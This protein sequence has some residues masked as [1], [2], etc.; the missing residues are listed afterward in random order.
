[1]LDSF[2]YGVGNF[3]IAL[4]LVGIFGAHYRLISE[5]GLQFI[6]TIMVFI[7]YAYPAFIVLLFAF[8]LLRWFLRK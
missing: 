8:R 1:M 6:A 3:F 2:S 4:A 7:I 5:E